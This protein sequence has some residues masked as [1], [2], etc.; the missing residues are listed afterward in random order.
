MI[1]KQFVTA[2]L[3]HPSMF[4]LIIPDQL[5]SVITERSFLLQESCVDEHCNDVIIVL[6]SCGEIGIINCATET[7]TNDHEIT[8]CR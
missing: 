3:L 4:V 2:R 8:I 6:L 7:K 5:S 1:E